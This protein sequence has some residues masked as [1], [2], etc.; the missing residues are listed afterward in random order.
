MD[1]KP[2]SS[3]RFFLEWLALNPIGFTLGSLSGAT[4]MGFVPMVIPGLL[5]LILGDL[6]FGGMIG[7]TQYFVFRRT[8][9][10]PVSGWWV[11]AKAIGFTM[12][13]RSGSLLT[14][15]ITEDWSLAGVVFGVIMGMSIG[16]ATAVV[17]FKQ[18]SPPRL[19]LWIGICVLAWVAGESI[20]FASYFRLITVPLVALA[21]AGVTGLGF[22][23]LH[24]PPAN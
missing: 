1:K 15:R 17:L 11:I 24:H 12:G 19:L 7:F 21:I 8:G 13:A 4:S 20:A 2:T 16:L 3:S 9:F 5:G 14:F 18:F 6:I 22:K 10:L 23:Y